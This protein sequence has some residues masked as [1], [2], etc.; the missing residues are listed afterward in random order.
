MNSVPYH[1]DWG[2]EHI[3]ENGYE[4]TREI[5]TDAEVLGR[6]CRMLD[7]D[8]LAFFVWTQRILWRDRTYDEI[9]RRLALLNPRG[10]TRQAIYDRIKKMLAK[11]NSA[12]PSKLVMPRAKAKQRVKAKL[13]TFEKEQNKYR[14]Q[15]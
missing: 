9:A 6:L 5:H 3:A 12:L 13:T 7:D 1:E 11:E 14:R 10:V 2:D 15:G 4:P 8:P